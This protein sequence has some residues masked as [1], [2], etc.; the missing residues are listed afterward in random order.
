M[1][2]ALTVLALM[3]LTAALVWTA[4]W[5]LQFEWLRGLS[6]SMQ[7]VYESAVGL[8]V[9]AA[10]GSA[11]RWNVGV[12]RSAQDG[13]RWIGAGFLLLGLLP[14]LP[15]LPFLPSMAYLLK[16]RILLMGFS[17]ISFSLSC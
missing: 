14:F 12:S 6:V 5:L 1:K 8:I 7:Y 11:L 15:A 4:A 3:I 16:Y 9:G 13:L 2:R 17:G 10:A